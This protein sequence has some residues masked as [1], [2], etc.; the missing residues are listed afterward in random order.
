MRDSVASALAQIL[1][2]H[3]K[4]SLLDQDPDHEHLRRERHQRLK[5]TEALYPDSKWRVTKDTRSSK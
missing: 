3:A 2:D 5:G 1:R 4:S